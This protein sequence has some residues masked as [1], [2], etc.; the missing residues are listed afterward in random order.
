MKRIIL[1]LTIFSLL[2]ADLYAQGDSAREEKVTIEGH[3]FTAYITGTDTIIMADLDN[4]S[5][6]SPKKF[7]NS[8]DRRRYRKY[9]FY[10]AKVYPYAL[11]AIRIFKD[12]EE[13]TVDMSKRKRKRYLRKKYKQ[14]KREFKKPLKNLTKT[15]GMLLIKMIEKELDTPFYDLMK[16]VRGGFTAS[17]WHQ[18]GK[19]YNY[20]LKEG[21]VE[22]VDPILDVVL[23]DFDV[24]YKKD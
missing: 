15:Q 4:I 22:G 7:K 18:M 8:A 17:Y 9:R 11:K 14:L 5:V 24:S 1:L 16:G 10:G 19:F 23:Y 2:N 20:N 13:K 3:V 12:V 6:S 21:Y